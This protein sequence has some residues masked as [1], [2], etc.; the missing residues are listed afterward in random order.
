MDSVPEGKL[1]L[2]LY[3][4]VVH[5]YITYPSANHPPKVMV[6]AAMELPGSPIHRPRTGLRVAAAAL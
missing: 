3:A 5:R 2:R 4:G 1:L 6:T